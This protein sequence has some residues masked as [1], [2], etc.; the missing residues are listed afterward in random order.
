[1]TG[2]SAI[3]LG[4]LDLVTNRIFWKSLPLIGVK[5]LLSGSALTLPGF[6]FIVGECKHFFFFLRL[7]AMKTNENQSDVTHAS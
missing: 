7:G 3:W 6:F 2:A 4:H 1:M 5:V